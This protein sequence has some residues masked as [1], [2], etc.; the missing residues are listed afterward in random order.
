[1]E[2]TKARPLGLP[3][4]ALNMALRREDLPTLERPRKAISGAAEDGGKD[5]KCWDEKRKAGLWE[6]LVKKS[7]A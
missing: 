5:R 2:D 7:W 6:G 1:L 3:D 4:L